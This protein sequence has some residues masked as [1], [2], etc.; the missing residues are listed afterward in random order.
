M[1]DIISF[2]YN[3][4]EQKDWFGAKPERQQWIDAE[5][6]KRFLSDYEAVMAGQHKEWLETAEGYLAFCLLLDQFPRHMF[7]ATPKAFA[8][9]FFALAIAKEAIHK[10]V[11]KALE[12]NQRVFLY[13]PFEHAEDINAQATAVKKIRE[14]ESDIYTEYA[15]LHLEVIVKFGRFPHRNSILGRVSTPQEMEYL[16]KGGGF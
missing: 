9:D 5:I 12:V 6:T 8:S 1:N 11:D 10:G 3:E 2:W 16:N 7:R 15:L 4:L 14:L 13:L